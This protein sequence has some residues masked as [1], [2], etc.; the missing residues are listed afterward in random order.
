MG[1]VVQAWFSPH[2]DRRGDKAYY[3]LMEVGHDSFAAFLADVATGGMIPVTMLHTRSGEARYER[4]VTARQ[5]A[6]IRG[7]AIDRMQ[8]SVFDLVEA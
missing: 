8:L 4:I 3:E 7:E 1:I 2:A 5:Q 6:A